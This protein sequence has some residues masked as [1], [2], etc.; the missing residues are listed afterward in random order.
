MFTITSQKGTKTFVSAL[1]R[2][3]KARNLELS[4][5][6]LLDAVAIA[7]GFSGSEELNKKLPETSS[8]VARSELQSSWNYPLVN[9][10][11][12]D[13]SN[14]GDLVDGKTLISVSGTLEDILECVAWATEGTRKSNGDIEPDHLG[15]TNVNWDAQK[16]RRNSK[17]MLQFTLEGEQSFVSAEGLF[18]VPEGLGHKVTQLFADPHQTVLPVR[19]ELVAE[20]VSFYTNSVPLRPN[21]DDVHAVS[22]VCQDAAQV[23]GFR[24]TEAELL[25][26]CERMKAK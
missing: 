19:S 4:H 9:T 6:K 18:I 20:Y 11:Q 13:F 3:L 24:M 21:I 16:G 10:G 8:P 14:S 5:N 23:I 26:F 7:M 17:G 22:A 12:F 25:V 1:R 15:E 2:E